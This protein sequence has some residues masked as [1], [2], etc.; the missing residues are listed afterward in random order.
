MKKNMIKYV[1]TLIILLP[2][3][4][5][6]KKYPDG[7]ALSFRSKTKRLENDWKLDKYFRNGVDATS[8]LYISG[9]TESFTESGGYTR[10]FIDQSGDAINQTGTWK[11]DG[12]KE[13]IILS[14]VGS[15]ELSPANSTVT[16]SSITILRLKEKELWYE[17]E[18]GG[19]V[20][21]FHFVEK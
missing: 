8:T 19:D 12:S 2:V 1:L 11:F 7:P 20:H 5:S 21:K 16:A 3:L 14:G 17:F 18:N 9:Y 6:C 15:F 10:A 4:E 13:K